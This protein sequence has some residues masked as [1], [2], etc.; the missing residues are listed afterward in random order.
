MTWD[1]VHESLLIRI[2][3]AFYV[4]AVALKFWMLVAFQR[5]VMIPC[6]YQ[7]QRMAILK[8]EKCEKCQAQNW[9]A[10]SAKYQTKAP[11]MPGSYVPDDTFAPTSVESTNERVTEVSGMITFH[12]TTIQRDF[13]DGSIDL[14]LY[15]RCY[16]SN[17]NGSNEYECNAF[18]SELISYRK[19]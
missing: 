13:K 12:E 1:A 11:R 5:D 18:S 8:A 10:I 3:A 4:A 9:E 15:M 17:R 19:Y 7:S 2:C 16:C 6:T 14:S